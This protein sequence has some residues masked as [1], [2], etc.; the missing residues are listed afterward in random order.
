M[1]DKIKNPI[2][3]IKNAILRD[4]KAGNVLLKFDNK[5]F[6]EAKKMLNKKRS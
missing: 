6:K 5:S 2:D 3:I 4:M 1:K